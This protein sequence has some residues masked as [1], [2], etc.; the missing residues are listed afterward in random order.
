LDRKP[1]IENLVK[2]FRA[3]HHTIV[4]VSQSFSAELKIT[5]TQFV[6]LVIVNENEGISIKDLAHIMGMTSSAA[7]QQVDNLVKKGYLIRRGSLEDRR[8]LELSLSEEIRKQLNATKEQALERLD[9]TFAA[10]TDAE[11]LIFCRLNE[12]IAG[13]LLEK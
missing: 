10:L 13:R 5:Y 3:V 2:S 1:Q 9:A 11:F 12:K 4:R 6:L 8:T 7:T